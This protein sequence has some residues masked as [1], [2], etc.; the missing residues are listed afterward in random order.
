M[1]RSS[2]LLNLLALVLIFQAKRSIF[3]QLLLLLVHRF[4]IRTG[5]LL[6]SGTLFLLI[7]SHGFLLILRIPVYNYYNFSN[8]ETMNIPKQKS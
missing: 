7:L 1:A 4:L 2:I 6:L 5:V 8:S 3:D